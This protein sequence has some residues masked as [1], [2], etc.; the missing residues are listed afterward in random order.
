M[1]YHPTNR[2]T[3]TGK[4]LKWWPVLVDHFKLVHWCYGVLKTGTVF[5]DEGLKQVLST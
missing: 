1:G 5:N 3:D 4:T 2:K